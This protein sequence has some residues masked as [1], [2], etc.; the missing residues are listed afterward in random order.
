M[1]DG[2]QLLELARNAQRPFAKQ[3][4]REKRCLLNFVLSN[5]I[6]ENGELVVTFREPLDLL[7]EI[8]LNAARVVADETAKRAKT[9]IWLGN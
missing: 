6:W 2:V 4:S 8:T 3:E 7:A 9:E 5:C 1:Y